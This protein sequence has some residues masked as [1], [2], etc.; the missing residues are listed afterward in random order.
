MD[1]DAFRLNALRDTAQLLPI[2][3]NVLY[4]AVLQ[5]RPPLVSSILR[6]TPSAPL[7]QT[8]Y[9]SAAQLLAGLLPDE[10]GNG[11]GCALTKEAFFFS[12]AGDSSFSYPAFF[13][14]FGPL[15]VGCVVRFSRRLCKLLHYTNGYRWKRL[16]LQCLNDNH[17]DF[18]SLS[19]STLSELDACA[20]PHL[21]PPAA[22]D[23]AQQQKKSEEERPGSSSSSSSRRSSD[24]SPHPSCPY[25]F[26]CLPELKE[27]FPEGRVPIVF[28]SGL[29]AR[30]S[31]N[32][33]TLMGCFCVLVLG[34]LPSRFVQLLSCRYSHD[35]RRPQLQQQQ[36]QSNVAPPASSSSAAVR[37]GIAV[38]AATSPSLTA[39]AATTA[40]L[41]EALSS[42]ATHYRNDNTPTA[43]LPT[44]AIVST[45][46]FPP[47]VSLSPPPLVSTCTAAGS[48]HFYMP[49]LSF[50]DASAGVTNY[51]LYMEDVLCAVEKAVAMHWLNLISFDMV[52]F[53]RLKARDCT[54]VIPRKVMALSSPDDS[55]K[56]RDGKR[57]A[58]L[59]HRE[60]VSMLLRLNEPLYSAAEFHRKGIQ[61]ADAE[62][63]DGS[64]PLDATVHKFL[65]LVEGVL[66]ER[67]GVVGCSSKKKVRGGVA[68]AAGAAIDGVSPHDGPLVGGVFK[69]LPAAS[70][71]D[72]KPLEPCIPPPAP[73]KNAPGDAS[74]CSRLLKKTNAN[75]N[76]SGK[77]NRCL[78]AVAVHCRAGLGRTGTM[79][80]IYIMRHY[81]LSARET[82]AW[83]RLCRP[84]SVS[85]IQQ[86]FLETVERRMAPPL[87]VMERRE[88]NRPRSAT[89]PP[90]DVAVAAAAAAAAEA[91]TPSRM[92]TAGAGSAITYL[93]HGDTHHDAD[94]AQR[95]PT[96]DIRP[97]SELSVSELDKF[98]ASFQ[99]AAEGGGGGTATVPSGSRPP[100]AGKARQQVEEED[101]S[102]SAKVPPA[103]AA[104][105]S[106]WCPA[107][108]GS[109]RLDQRTKEKADIAAR[110][111]GSSITDPSLRYTAPHELM[112]GLMY[113]SSYLLA[114]EVS[115][116]YRKAHAMHQSFT[117]R[118]ATPSRSSPCLEASDAKSL[119]RVP[120]PQLGGGPLVSTP[121]SFVPLS[122]PQKQQPYVRSTATPPN[123]IA[124]VGHLSS[125]GSGR[126]ATTPSPLPPAESKGS[127]LNGC[128]SAIR[129]TKCSEVQSGVAVAGEA[130]SRHTI[131][132][133]TPVQPAA[134]T[135][136]ASTP[137]A[138]ILRAAS[139]RNLCNSSSSC[140]VSPHLV[141][142][143]PLLA[144]PSVESPTRAAALSP[145]PTSE[146]KLMRTSLQQSREQW[147][148]SPGWLAPTLKLDALV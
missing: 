140:R 51:P 133:S 138:A 146:S 62:F 64:T 106:G 92:S 105:G 91:L 61:V 44:P 132:S 4:F 63:R 89:T 22:P 74:P 34:W 120:T 18:S 24:G 123:L 32:A 45:S 77:K 16:A 42:T 5:E 75:V 53:L 95:P 1:S 139:S 31:E 114:L 59:L 145:S 125:S 36:Q 102:S 73:A 19:P 121:T 128:S 117:T 69:G 30:E 126:A 96:Q 99:L 41:P 67:P 141:S 23:A 47:S 109:H 107:L 70:T 148:S 101:S 85:G 135:P 49:H 113:P 72:V 130:P 86:Q 110:V 55:V 93:S 9:G 98:S 33:V 14:D 10:G 81:F 7:A 88:S 52:W 17:C 38:A 12:T 124:S 84:G 26:E 80:G 58:A 15:D 35:V 129:R 66:G 46:A 2:I 108:E 68:A 131:R 20:A 142:P 112:E 11:G 65:S 127:N 104:V 39:T 79:I 147:R 137:V 115:R 48:C 71:C 40:P 97:F 103:A 90:S 83:L 28:C 78:G 143:P 29:D 56:A 111:F 43:S 6:P 134:A 76:T 25:V 100:T 60:G 118:L 27:A 54:W 57:W 87:S 50:R 136:C 94:R 122:D 116:P 21:F 119:C 13:E 3:P 82:I 144:F 8:V 37:Q